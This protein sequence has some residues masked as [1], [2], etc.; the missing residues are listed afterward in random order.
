[1]HLKIKVLRCLENTEFY[2][3]SKI[4][5]QLN[6][7]G[8]YSYSPHP[9]YIS[10]SQRLTYLPVGGG[11]GGAIPPIGGPRGAPLNGGGGGP[12]REGG[13]GGG[14]EPN[15]L[16]GGGGGGAEE[17]RDGG[18]GGGAPLGGPLPL[19]GGGGGGISEKIMKVI[20]GQN[21]PVLEF[22]LICTKT[23]Y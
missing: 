19:A 18:G 23:E 21:D 20:Y 11:G 12:P 9:T 4:E 14:P 13:G 17:P 15:P 1:M 10:K 22:T 16:E 7:A 2:K 3:R 5:R 6:I 8:Y